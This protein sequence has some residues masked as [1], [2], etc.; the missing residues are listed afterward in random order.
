MKLELTCEMSNGTGVRIVL[1]QS[2]SPAVAYSFMSGRGRGQERV[3]CSCFGLV[4]L[5]KHVLSADIANI[6][7]GFCYVLYRMLKKFYS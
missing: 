4:L 1:I 7:T 6:H 2:F 3:H 5:T